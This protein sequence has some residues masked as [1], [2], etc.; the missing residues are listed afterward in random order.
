MG[1]VH[2]PTKTDG[3]GPDPGLSPCGQIGPVHVTTDAGKT[4][5]RRGKS[6]LLLV[7]IVMP[8]ASG[9]HKV[10]GKKKDRS[11]K[12]QGKKKDRSRRG[13]VQQKDPDAVPQLP[14]KRA[15]YSSSIFIGA[16][17]SIDPF[18]FLLSLGQK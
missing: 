14:K 15:V 6:K 3:S 5:E 10:Q 4:R 1:P 13:L 16:V 17:P 7:R 2:V 11:H 8:P 12:V 9:S 18:Q